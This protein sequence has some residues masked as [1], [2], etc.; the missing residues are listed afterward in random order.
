MRTHTH[1]AQR[2]DVHLPAD[3]DKAS[4][5]RHAQGM[6]VYVS[7]MNIGTIAQRA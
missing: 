4:L 1:A 3:S 6:D 5:P 7:T 2:T